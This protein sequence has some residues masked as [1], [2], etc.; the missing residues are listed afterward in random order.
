MEEAGDA[1]GKH[2]T[3]KGKKYLNRVISKITEE[4][5]KIEECWVREEKRK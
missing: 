4:M 1:Q 3:T 2:A 5:Y